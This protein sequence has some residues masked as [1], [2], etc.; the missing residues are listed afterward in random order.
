MPPSARPYANPL[1]LTPV[2]TD[3]HTNTSSLNFYGLDALPAAQPTVSK[4]WRFLAK[5][6][7]CLLLTGS[8]IFK[9][10]ELYTE[11]NLMLFVIHVDALFCVLFRWAH[12]L[13]PTA[14]LFL[15]SH[16]NIAEIQMWCGDG[17][18]N[19]VEEN[20]N[21]NAL[22]ATSKYLLAEKLCCNK[23][24]QFLTGLLTNTGWPVGVVTKRRKAAFLMLPAVSGCD[25]HVCVCAC[26]CACA[27]VC[28]CVNVCVRACVIACV[29]VVEIRRMAACL[30]LSA[31]SG[32]DLC[33]WVCVCVCM[34]VCARVHMCARACV[35][36]FVCA[37][38]C[39][40]K[41]KGSVP[42]IV[43]CERLAV[44]QDGQHVLYGCWFLHPNETF[45]VATRKFLQK[46]W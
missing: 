21:L 30:T 6:E 38:L 3:S 44:N 8:D 12:N 29:H 36:A 22:V 5:V 10:C 9:L 7:I 15:S 37:C 24:L 1:H 34:R 4:H 32:C 28:M 45:H 18:A 39:R 20:S 26:V 13:F 46:V 31:V 23:I 17:V 41:E 42:H 35:I 11:G 25:L 2:Q 27:C 19:V 40:D 33:E 16:F 14:F 43:C